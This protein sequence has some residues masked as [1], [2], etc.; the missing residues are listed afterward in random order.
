MS[1]EAASGSS[2]VDDE[3]AL[4]LQDV[5][6]SFGG[7]VA[8][9]GVNLSI[10]RGTVHGLIGHNGA[11][12]STLVKI[13]AGALR[14]DEGRVSVLGDEVELS[15]PQDAAT[16]G[17][18]VLH[19]DLSLFP[20]LSVAEN[21]WL[22]ISSIDHSR[23]LR[24]QRMRQVAQSAL[25]SVGAEIDSR[26]QVSQLSFSDQQLVALARV[27]QQRPRVVV[28]DEPTSGLG[29]EEAAR[30]GTILADLV[31]TGVS[32]LF[33][34]HRLSEVLDFCDE[35]TVLRDGRDVAQVQGSG[36]NKTQLIKHVMGGETLI[37]SS[38]EKSAASSLNTSDV[39]L[40][41]GEVSHLGRVM[42][43]GLTLARGEI[44]GV[45]GLPGSG[46]E[47]LIYAIA[48]DRRSGSAAHARFR[49]RDY[50]R[51]EW[52]AQRPGIGFVPSDRAREGVF[53]NRS[54]HENI[55]VGARRPR[56]LV[57]RRAYESSITERLVARLHVRLSRTR[58]P[59]INLSGGNQQKVVLARA[60]AAAND[61]IVMDE[62]TNGVDVGSRADIHRSVDEMSTEGMGLLIGS[63]DPEELVDICHRI[64]VMCDRVVVAE[65]RPPFDVSRLMDAATGGVSP[66]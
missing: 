11:G 7:T 5:H 39:L 65:Y 28:L 24:P 25:A 40:E 33:V 14:P 26:A 9:N 43:P 2:S 61:V 45:F 21:V 30:L 16:R 55:V 22:G 53:P 37:A 10:R 48:G 12:K 29:P 6:K 66:D 17:V 35:I 34:S 32:A 46:R 38:H 62:P 49:E 18:A 63:T 47:N 13:V 27:M 19:Q 54:I 60:L 44:L 50:R 20:D 4:E 15:G 8:L 31:R 56:Q 64:L 41:L 59:V 57:R 58:D 23:W 36:T 42:A 52:S 1:I 3:L 51:R